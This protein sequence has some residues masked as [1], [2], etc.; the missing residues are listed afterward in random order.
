MK[1]IDVHVGGVDGQMLGVEARECDQ[2]QEYD[3]S[4]G[5]GPEPPRQPDEEHR[6][7]SVGKE[8]AKD[9]DKKAKGP[10]REKAFKKKDTD[11]DGFLTKE[12]FTKGAKDAEKA[13]KSFTNKD[14]DKDGKVS[15]AEFTA[16]PRAK[17]DGDKKGKKKDGEKK[18]E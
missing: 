8:A 14:K 6:K 15:L 2:K 18:A 3:V 5:A 17:K 1:V 9:G 10:D 13:A 16:A 12:E 11:G 4:R 7:E